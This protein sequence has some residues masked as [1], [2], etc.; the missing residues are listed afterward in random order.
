[1]QVA[2]A[3]D[4]GDQEGGDM[5]AVVLGDA[6]AFRSGTGGSGKFHQK[7]ALTRILER[8]TD[9]L[10]KNTLNALGQIGLQVKAFVHEPS[11]DNLSCKCPHRLEI[12]VVR[13]ALVHDLEAALT[14]KLRIRNSDA[15]LLTQLFDLRICR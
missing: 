11:P 2:L 4:A 13:L 1:M 6:A 7:R 8:C 5:L 3:G 9:R 12:L 15:R 10:G 14:V